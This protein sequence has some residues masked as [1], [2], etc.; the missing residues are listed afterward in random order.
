MKWALLF[1]AVLALAIPAVAD[2][3]PRNLGP[4][5]LGDIKIG[6]PVDKVELLL[7]N[8]LGYNPFANRGCSVLTTPKLEP[9]G[10]SLMIE[11]RR[12]TRIN[13]DY[14]GKSP[15]P[16]TFKTDAGIGLGSTEQDV[17]KAYP[18]ARVKANPADPTWHTIIADVPDHSKGI[19]FETDGKTVKSMRAGS[20]PA[21][22]Y[23]NGCD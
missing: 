17:L 14:V 1:P 6:M 9:T 7:S 23:A 5:G 13:V 16:E 19:V 15:I 8:K 21:I 10:L 20:N 2:D 18:D 4:D 11:S 22:S 12:L 3:L